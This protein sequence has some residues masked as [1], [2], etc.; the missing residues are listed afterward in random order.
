MAAKTTNKRTIIDNLEKV[1]I[2]LIFVSILVYYVVTGNR[3]LK[4]GLLYKEVLLLETALLFYYIYLTKNLYSVFLVG[5]VVLNIG[6]FEYSNNVKLSKNLIL[7]G[8]FSQ[9]FFGAFLGYKTVKESIKNKDWEMFGTLM[10]IALMFPIIYRYLL[11]GKELLIIYKYALPFLLGII[12]YNENLWDKYN[13]S[14]KKILTYVLVSMVA[15]VLFISMKL[16]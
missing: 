11:S 6:F 12:V 3:D 15:E 1:L 9:F 10:T 8:E 2:A 13:N 14:E 4:A 5:F 16:I 7:I